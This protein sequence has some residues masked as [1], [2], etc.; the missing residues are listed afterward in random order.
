MTYW[1]DIYLNKWATLSFILLFATISVYDSIVV[2]LSSIAGTE[3]SKNSNVIIFVIFF[4]F[5]G[6]STRFLLISSREDKKNRHKR[7]FVDKFHIRGILITALILT[8]TITLTIIFQ[9]TFQGKYNLTLLELQTAISRLSGLALLTP[10][11]YLFASWSISKKSYII[12]MYTLSLSLIAINLMI[13]SV[14]LLY[15]QSYYSFSPFTSV[16]PFPIHIVGANIPTSEF[17]ESLHF[18]F[19]ILSLTSFFLMWIATLISLLH[20]RQRMGKIK[21][22]VIMNIPLIYYVFPF[23]NYIAD[24]FPLLESTPIYISV[25]YVLFFSASEQVAA[26]LFSLVF[27]TS[28]TLVYN[29]NYQRNLLISVVGMT[30]I[31]GSIEISTLQYRLYPPFGL[32]T[33]AFIPLGAYLLLVGIFNSAKQMS[34]DAKLRKDFYTVANS[35]INV[36]RTIGVTQMEKELLRNFKLAEERTKYTDTIE[37]HYSE[38]DV[39]QIVREVLEELKSRNSNIKEL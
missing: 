29:N 21:Y 9:I 12:A 28:S 26:L 3:L 6:I 30:I 17:T 23:H 1:Q 37:E 2:K 36:L 7:S 31:F 13:S 14:Y 8:F 22:Y 10:L 24:L 27:W 5:Y 38:Q 15:L 18:I 39:R 19:D 25:L 34:G 4:T 11:I 16:N 32:I 33:Q 20:Y 35:R